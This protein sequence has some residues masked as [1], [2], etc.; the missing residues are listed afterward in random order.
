MRWQEPVKEHEGVHLGALGDRLCQ[1]GQADQQEQDEGNRGEQGVERQG[2][3]QKW[4]V[5]FVGGLKGATKKAG[6]GVM[7]PAGV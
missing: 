7:P 1:V 6:G 4:N 3:G 5:V 2:A